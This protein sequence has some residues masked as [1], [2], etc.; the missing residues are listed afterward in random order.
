VLKKSQSHIKELKDHIKEGTL[1]LQKKK[2]AF[3]KISKMNE[4]KF[5][6]KKVQ[7]KKEVKKEERAAVK[8][9]EKLEAK[10]ELKKE[11]KIA[12]TKK[13]SVKN[14]LLRSTSM[15]VATIT[16]MIIMHTT[17]K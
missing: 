4:P 7:A 1:V 2:S 5:E 14:W 10:K 17:A 9:E 6:A 3:E 16:I 13:E 11:S 8:K 12:D 15:L